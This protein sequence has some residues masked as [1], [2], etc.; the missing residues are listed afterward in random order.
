MER[1]IQDIFLG[2][3]LYSLEYKRYG[4]VSVLN[5]KTQEI[6]VIFNMFKMRVT[7]TYKISHLG[8]ALFFDSNQVCQGVNPYH[9][10]YR[11]YLHNRYREG[12]KPPKNQ[13]LPTVYNNFRKSTRKSF[14]VKPTWTYLPYVVGEP[15]I[16]DNDFGPIYTRKKKRPPNSK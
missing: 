2:D 16:E 15:H 1:I 4:C 5:S 3:R 14:K 8:V 9:N 12:S 6:I 7:H 10:K 13:E 11:V